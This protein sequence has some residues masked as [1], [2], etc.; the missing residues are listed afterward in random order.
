[1]R[2]RCFIKNHNEMERLNRVGWI[3]GFFILVLTLSVRAQKS[4]PVFQPLTWE[5][6]AAQAQK[7]GKIVLVDAMRKAN[8]AEAQKKQEEAERDLLKTPGVVEFC[9]K[10]VVAIHIDMS[11]EE[12]KAFAPKLVMNMYPTYGF[13][14]PNGD[15]LGVVSPYTLTKKPELFVEA[16]EK[17][18]K[19]AVVK[20]ENSRSIDFEEITLKDAMVKAQKEN[21][22]I[23][24]DAYT[25]YCQPCVLMV[26]NVFSLNHVADFYN[27][28]FINLKIHFG[29]E[30]ELAEKYG[31]RGYPSFLFIN[32]DGKL[33]HLAGGYSEADKFIG[34]G[35]EA[36]KK[37]KGIEFTDGNWQQVLEKAKSENKIIFMDCY[38]SWCA[39]CK[40]MAKTVFTDPEV[41][42]FFNEKF[43]NVKVDM[44]KGEGKD[45]KDRYEVSAYP[46]L[47]FIGTDG[48][49]AHC[50]VGGVNANELLKQ[51]GIA[52]SGK[53]LTSMN[54][55]YQSG[56][57][58]PGFIQEYLTALD[59]AN[60]KEDAEKV[61]LDYFTTLD[62]SKL[63]EKECWNLF[64][65]Y[66]NDV[67]SEVFA[68]VYDNRAEFCT[69]FGDKE[70]KRKI[71]TVWAIGANKFVSGKGAEAVLD[72]KGFK[73]YV[74]RLEKAD[75]DGKE[76]IIANAR[77]SNAEKVG[78]WKTYIVL[79]TQQLKNGMVS[80]LT[81]YNW[82]LRV[83]KQCKDKALRLQAA[84]WFD[85]A[86]AASAKREEA[87][88]G[89]G[90]MSYRTYFEKL[91]KELKTEENS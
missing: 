1:M 22:L 63:K 25:D 40:Q 39:P 45:L 49:I 13:F 83:S 62:K 59:L 86:A 53:G 34:Y 9:K 88:G 57:R 78:D 26:K 71:S 28:N 72:Q 69:L 37:A 10:N 19:N 65:K 44:E 48:E 41:A 24:I 64:A 80:D 5:Q 70:V 12:G 31:T 2:D 33:V 7:E 23:F 20:R 21:K 76:S 73:R 84:Q 47:N 51:A 61:T 11:T 85:D 42:A 82:G 32:G 35:Q 4:N 52:L 79:G 56:N 68:Y 54:V 17:A 14:M 87:A 8:N 16:G 74:K 81:L 36:L 15:I 43:V 66:I 60:R 75:V 6:A 67:N 27:Q 30:K 38:T 50:V 55:A 90:M 18:V 77:M 46:T 58:T 91:A 3:V 89:K 29:K